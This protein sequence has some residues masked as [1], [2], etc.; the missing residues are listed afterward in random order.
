[1]E[2]ELIETEKKE[3]KEIEKRSLDLEALDRNH[4]AEDREVLYNTEQKA[5]NSLN[6]IRSIYNGAVQLGLTKL[7]TKLKD[8]QTEEEI[9]KVVGE[10]KDLA[11]AEDLKNLTMATSQILKNMKQIYSTDP[12]IILAGGGGMLE[13]LF[14]G[15]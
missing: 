7:A 6:S 12:K 11:G 14:G 3:S 8:A 10:I 1:M 13:K 9:L 4:F 15:L 2:Q 5:Y